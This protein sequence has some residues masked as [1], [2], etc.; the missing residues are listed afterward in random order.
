MLNLNNLDQE[1]QYS[2]T[3]SGMVKMLTKTPKDMGCLQSDE[4]S[5][6]KNNK[7]NLRQKLKSGLKISTNV[8]IVTKLRN[9]SCPIWSKISTAKEAK[10][11]FW[12]LDSH[13]IKSIKQ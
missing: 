1:D 6:K 4:L 9:L 7:R 12:E 3:S 8:E 13:K 11:Y 10:E 2:E 5:K